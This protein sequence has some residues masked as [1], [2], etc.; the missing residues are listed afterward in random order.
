ML[1]FVWP[2][3]ALL[4]SLVLIRPA[5]ASV[6]EGLLA[7]VPDS[8]VVLT[9]VDADATRTSGFGQYLLRRMDREDQHLQSFA[10]ETG[11]DPRRDIQTLL[12]AGFRER[13]P[14]SHQSNSRQ[15]NSR[16]AIL[17]RGTFDPSRIAAAVRTRNAFA[18]QTYD[19][20]TLFVDKRPG[21]DNAFAFPDAGVAVMG[22]V[23]T[24]KQILDRRANPATLDPGLLERV[25]KIGKSNDVWFASLLSGSFL[26]NHIELPGNAAQLKDSSALQS[27]LQSTGGVRFGDEVKVS[28]EATTRSPEDATS[29][30]DVVR[31]LSSMIQ[32]QRGND[33]NTAILASAF[34][35]MQLQATGS[36]FRLGLSISEKNLE[37]L[38]QS[39]AK[40]E[41]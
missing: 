28:F 40:R 20:T 27:I 1:R 16:Y 3:C 19:G 9:S 34:D 30:A 6:D 24:V 32:T 4:G 18:P 38:A 2:V 17:A 36:Q 29:L 7:L 11:F 26:S 13:Q 21:N 39:S 5:A 15:P 8:T 10:D 33:A 41:Q 35:K 12:F 37:A 23:G 22:D 25:N 31:F 14:N